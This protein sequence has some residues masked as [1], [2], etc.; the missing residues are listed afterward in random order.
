M[1]VYYA[2]KPRHN[3]LKN[4]KHVLTADFHFWVKHKHYVIRK[5]FV[6]D[7]ASIPKLMR[8]KY[9]TP[10]DPIHLIGGL[11]HDAIYANEVWCVGHYLGKAAFTRLQADNIYFALIRLKGSV[12]LRAAKEWAAVRFFGYT[13]WYNYKKGTLMKKIIKILG[14]ILGALLATV[15]LAGCTTKARSVEVAGMYANSTG[16]LAIGSVDVTSAPQGEESAFVKYSEDT[17]WLSPSTKTHEIKIMLTGTNSTV[18]VDA[19]VKNICEAF[20]AVKPQESATGATAEVV[21][22]AL[23]K[24]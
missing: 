9:G 14:A 1:N 6:W 15:V 8:W 19:L 5:G 13:H 3:D 18:K 2:N 24:K 10:F 20:V 22:D 16:T 21:K 4:G 7:G 11:V 12:Y 23:D 17:A